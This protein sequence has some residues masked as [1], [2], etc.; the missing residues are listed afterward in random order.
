VAGK[1][2]WAIIAAILG[3]V[4]WIVQIGLNAWRH[5]P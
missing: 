3:G 4:I 1:I 2:G 5:L